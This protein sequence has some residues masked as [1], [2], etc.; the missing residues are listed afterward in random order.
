MA[1][2]TFGS[3]ST[4]CLPRLKGEEVFGSSQQLVDCP[5][6]INNDSHC[7]NHV[8]FSH[9]WI[10]VLIAKPNIVNNVHM[11]QPPSSSSKLLPLVSRGGLELKESVCVN[12]QWHI[13]H[14]PPN[15]IIQ[16][17]TLQRTTMLKCKAMI[18]LYKSINGTPPPCYLGFCVQYHNGSL[19]NHNHCFCPDD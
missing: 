7:P 11:Q 14:C 2:Y 18:N 6:G 19:K 17:S 13:E 4:N 8:N 1:N 9:P 12:N 16:C 10:I 3:S 5:L 15:S